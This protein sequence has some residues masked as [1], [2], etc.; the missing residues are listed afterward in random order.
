MFIRT[1]GKLVFY[2]DQLAACNYISIIFIN[3]SQEIVRWNSFSIFSKMFLSAID[4][5]FSIELGEHSQ[6][7]FCAAELIVR[8]F[9]VKIVLFVVAISQ[10]IFIVI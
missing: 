7:P 4:R 8:S 6:K 5:R 9:P 1:Q 3:D 10:I 2:Y